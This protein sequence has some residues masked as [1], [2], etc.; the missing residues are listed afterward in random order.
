MKLSKQSYGLIGGTLIVALVLAG[1]IYANRPK[2][3]TVP[4]GTS[5]NV[6]LDQTLASNQSESGDVFAATVATPVVINEDTAIPAGARAKGRVVEARQSGRIRGTARL[7]LALTSVEFDG[8]IYNI[9]TNTRFRAGRNHNKNNLA[10]IGG[11]AGTGLI[12]GA[13]AGGG[14][15]AAIGGPIGAGA[16]FAAAFLTGKRDIR[17]PAETALTFELSEPV[18][19]EVTD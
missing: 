18:S 15:G 5:I 11:G 4:A 6:R 13:L 2:T 1:A 19:V 16:G 14:K 7:N 10:W 12:I 8:R 17:F 9:E 3:I